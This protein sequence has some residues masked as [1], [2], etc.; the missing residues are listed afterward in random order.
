MKAVRPLLLIIV[1]LAAAP[2][3]AA[4]GPPVEQMSTIW[5]VQP[6][7]P[8][9]EPLTVHRGD[10]ILEQKLLPAGLATLDAAFDG[11]EVKRPLPAASQ[12]FMVAYQAAAVYCAFQYKPP[13]TLLAL[14]APTTTGTQLCFVDSDQDRRFESYFVAS[15]AT[16]SLPGIYGPLPR[17]MRPM[18]SLAYSVVDPAAF[19]GD[20]SISIVFNGK[21]LV[22]NVRGYVISFG[23]K[24]QR[25]SLS[26]ET[27]SH[28]KDFP[29]TVEIM[30]ASISVL[31]GSGQTIVTRV[32]RPMPPQPFG[33]VRTVTTIYY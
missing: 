24:D 22:N 10:A 14:W 6:G 33:V 13:N 7:E 20:L 8:S 32:D 5:L 15:N 28:G 29:L 23:S 4:S 11:G 21:G 27:I 25:A 19:S 16:P 12:L 18:P 26:G 3:V 31:S 2:A 1:S 9:R 30:G 17:K